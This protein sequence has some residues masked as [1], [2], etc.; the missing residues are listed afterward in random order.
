[1][2]PKTIE[3]LNKI[4]KKLTKISFLGGDLTNF[5]FCCNGKA[6]ITDGAVA[7]AVPVD[8]KDTIYYNNLEITDKNCVPISCEN[9]R[10]LI[11]NKVA[12]PEIK[13]FGYDLHCDSDIDE[14]SY[15]IAEQ[16]NYEKLVSFKY[17]D[18]IFYIMQVF[19][20]TVR[21]ITIKDY[22]V[23]FEFRKGVFVLCMVKIPK[24]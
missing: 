3:K 7:I 23:E 18:L 9:L 24:E 5:I 14:I 21:K 19:K 6:F 13:S 8:F 17:L 11:E 4:R 20:T 1:M 15:F 16:Y 10:D 2:L 22:H 12:E